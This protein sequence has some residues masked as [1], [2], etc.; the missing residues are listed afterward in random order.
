[1][2]QNTTIEAARQNNVKK[3]MFLGSSCIYPKLAP[4][5]L[6]ENSLLTGPLEQTNE[7]YA[8][9]KIAGLKLWEAY[10]QL[11]GDD[12]ISAIPTN[13]YGP[14]DNFDPEAGHALPGMI[15]KFH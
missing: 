7:W 9:A 3:L 15:S 5:P 4:Q 12:F 1:M 10:R 8:I 2:I 6:H 11:S 13:L 14:F